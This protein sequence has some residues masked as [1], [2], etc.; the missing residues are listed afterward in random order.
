MHYVHHVSF[1]KHQKL[2]IASHM[3]CRASIT[4]HTYITRTLCIMHCVQHT[5][6][7]T[8]YSCRSHLSCLNHRHS[9]LRIINHHHIAHQSSIIDRSPQMSRSSIIITLRITDHVRT[10]NHKPLT[11]ASIVSPI[12]TL[13]ISYSLHPLKK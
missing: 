7:V 6:Y 11:I 9:Q 4:Q 13:L 12:I 1:I 5:S 3:K 10:I 2:H 8:H